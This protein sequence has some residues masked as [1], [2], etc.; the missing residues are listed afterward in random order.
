MRQ[1]DAEVYGQPLVHFPVVLHEALI[2]AVGF[3]VE[4]PVGCF[5]VTFQIARD[6]IRVFVAIAVGVA[7]LPHC[8]LAVGVVIGRLRVANPLP[9][10]TTLDRVG[11]H[12]LAERIAQVG[13]PFVR[14]QTRRRASH[15]ES[16]RIKHQRG[17]LAG[18]PSTT[19]RRDLRHSVLVQPGVVVAHRGAIHFRRIGEHVRE[20]DEGVAEHELVGHGRAEHV[21]QRTTD[22]VGLILAQH[23][24]RVGN[25]IGLAP[26]KSHREHLRLA[27]HVIAYEQLGAIANAIVHA[28]HPL[29]VVL[30]EDLRLHVVVT[31]GLSGVGIGGRIQLHQRHHVRVDRTCRKQPPRKLPRG[32]GAERSG[33]SAGGCDGAF[34]GDRRRGE[35]ARHLVCG[36]HSGAQQAGVQH[37]VEVLETGEEEQL[38]AVLVEPG[39]GNQHRAADGAAWIEVLVLRLRDTV[40]VVDPIVGVQ[41]VVA[42][43]EESRTVE[44]AAARLGDAANDHRALLVLSAEI[45][46]QDLEFGY[47]I[48]VGIDRGIAVAARVGNVR[49]VRGDVQRVAGQSVVRIGTVQ[50]AHAASVAIGVDA[51]HFARVVRRVAGAMADAKSR[52]DLDVLGGVAADLDVIL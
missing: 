11:S 27:L 33:R 51:D 12:H 47:H 43:V 40:L 5:V 46:S 38:V 28:R 1:A 7:S 34:P 25:L 23:R 24:G 31:A 30:I 26:P 17:F 39:A 29:R 50:R 20:P 15:F 42:G 32:C 19:E 16:T 18:P 52:H 2:R 49:A 4:V 14:V 10:E 9:E 36:W 6:Q 22:R 41:R 8:Q 44:F 3:V 48:R 37:L 45:P 21:G 35:I 13:H